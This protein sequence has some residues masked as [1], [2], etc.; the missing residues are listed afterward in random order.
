[1]EPIEAGSGT[2]RRDRRQAHRRARQAKRQTRE[3]KRRGLIPA[4]SVALGLLV[5]LSPQLLGGALGWT[6]LP[7]GALAAAAAAVSALAASAASVPLPRLYP[8]LAAGVVLTALQCVPLPVA[9]T[10][11]GLQPTLPLKIF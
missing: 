1:M 3:G 7:I 11:T 4:A 5:V 8:A 10:N 2:R 9:L 6:L